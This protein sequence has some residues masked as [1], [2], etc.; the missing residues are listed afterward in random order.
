MLIQLEKH[1]QVFVD[2]QI[3]GLCAVFYL[4]NNVVILSIWCKTPPCVFHSLPEIKVF[5]LIQGNCHWD[6]EEQVV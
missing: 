3:Q 1:H 2:I 4:I 5:F 6:K